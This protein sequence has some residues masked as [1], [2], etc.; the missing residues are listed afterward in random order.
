MQWEPTLFKCTLAWGLWNNA[1]GGALNEQEMES[2]GLISL[3]IRQY[4]K[5][6]CTRQAVLAE[7]CP[8]AHSNG[9]ENALLHCIFILL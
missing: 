8:V 5:A 7:I 4:Y 6:H 1:S 2:D 3:S 9:I